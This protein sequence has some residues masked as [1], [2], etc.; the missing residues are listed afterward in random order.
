MLYNPHRGHNS[1]PASS[2]PIPVIAEEWAQCTSLEGIFP[3]YSESPWTCHYQRFKRRVARY[4]Q[5][6]EKTFNTVGGKRH[7]GGQGKVCGKH[8]RISGNN[9]WK[10]RKEGEGG[11]RNKGWDAGKTERKGEMQGVS[12]KW[13]YVWE[14]NRRLEGKIE[15]K[16]ER[17]ANEIRTCTNN[18]KMIGI[19]AT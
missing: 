19:I 13:W 11:N 1:T 14:K 16:V 17:R 6:I 5:L 8:V 2:P 3:L 12:G 10:E 9:G 4:S 15:K 18:G 7:E